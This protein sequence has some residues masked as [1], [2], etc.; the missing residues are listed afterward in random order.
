[1]KSIDVYYFVDETGHS[2]SYEW[3]K[4]LPPKIKDKAYVRILRLEEK[5]HKIMESR[6]EAAY[7][8]D[9][10]YELRWDWQ[11][12]FY[13]L[14]FFFHQNTAA[15]LSHGILKTTDKVPLKEINKAIKI[16][17]LYLTNPEKYIMKI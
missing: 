16:K 6:T 17:Q 14:L 7:L 1:V 11:K 15:I 9:D 5:G 13:R 10:I 12:K 2:E 3:V 8:R 4:K